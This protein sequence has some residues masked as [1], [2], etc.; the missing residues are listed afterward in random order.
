MAGAEVEV[1]SHHC[2]EDFYPLELAAAAAATAAAAAA[3]WELVRCCDAL[4]QALEQ[5]A[6][7]EVSNELPTLSHSIDPSSKE[8]AVEEEEMVVAV[9][10]MI[11]AKT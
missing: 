8:V 5:E 6:Q 9:V 10:V 11:G 7:V 4:V 3:V 1:A 2:M